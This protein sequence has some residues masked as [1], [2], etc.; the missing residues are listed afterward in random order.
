MP[1]VAVNG[2]KFKLEP[3]KLKAGEPQV[4]LSSMTVFCDGKGVMAGPITVIYPVVNDAGY[5]PMPVIFTI[6]PTGN[7]CKVGGQPVV[8]EGDY[9]ETVVSFPPVGNYGPDVV[10]AKCTVEEAGQ[11]AVVYIA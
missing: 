1:D 5:A 10:N 9:G 4:L 7:R 8:I 6:N 2:L 11:T 3:A